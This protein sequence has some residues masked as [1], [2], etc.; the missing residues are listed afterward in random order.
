MKHKKRLLVLL[1]VLLLGGLVIPQL[2]AEFS[3]SARAEAALNQEGWMDEGDLGEMFIEDASANQVQPDG[4]VINAGEQ[5]LAKLVIPALA[6]QRR[7]SNVVGFDLDDKIYVES[8]GCIAVDPAY[9]AGNFDKRISLVAHLPLPDGT[10]I[11][12]FELNIKDTNST[13]IGNLQALVVRYEHNG[14]STVGMSPM[15]TD[16]PT[17]PWNFAGGT[18]RIVTDFEHTINNFTTGKEYAYI[19]LVNFPTNSPAGLSFCSVSVIYEPPLTG[20]FG[21]ALPYIQK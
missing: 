7:P 10:K 17:Y 11:R 9:V 20:M 13:P 6:F 19:L 14:A 3:P 1:T 5:G 16:S 18:L 15:L 8:N 21:I 4:S 12:Q 2:A